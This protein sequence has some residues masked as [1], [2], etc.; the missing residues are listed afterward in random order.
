MPVNDVQFNAEV[1]A[2]KA[3]TLEEVVTLH[4]LLSLE[5]LRRLVLRTPVDTGRARG[6]WQLTIGAASDAELG[7]L[8]PGGGAEL[9]LAVAKLA[10]LPPFS[11]VWISNNLDY[12]EVLEAGS[13]QQAPEGFFS[14]TVAE[15]GGLIAA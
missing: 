13:S 15:L 10:V 1:A 3:K 2:F 12:I 14:I 6:E 4:R 9:S 7:R 11:Q 8:D 5:M